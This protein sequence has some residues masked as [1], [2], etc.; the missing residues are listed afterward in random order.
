MRWRNVSPRLLGYTEAQR[1]TFE[2]NRYLKNRLLTKQIFIPTEHGSWVFLLSPLAIGLA[3][4]GKFGWPQV[5]WLVAALAAFM[6]RQ[7]LTV[8]VKILSGRRPRKDLLPA[9]FWLGMY[10]LIAFSAGAALAW[11]GFGFVLWLV[12]PAMLVMGWHLWLVSRKAER[13]K[14]G[15]E[16]IGSAVLALVA[17]A[18]YWIGRGGMDGYGWLLWL[19]LV[20]QNAAS[21][22]YAYLRLE[23]R[24]LPS[25]PDG[26]TRLSMGRRSLIYTTF[27]LVC[28]AG[29]SA[30]AVIPPWVWTA[31]LVQWCESL[32]GTWRPAIKERP[33]R[34]GIRQMIV[35][36]IFT[37][38]FVL[39]WFLK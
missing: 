19:L 24:V 13:R 26:K 32:Y 21:I 10:G 15:V 39:T 29:L 17:P 3:L 33:M 6:A 11:L 5:V 31:Y 14:P 35:S 8:L 4:G 30:A 22:V 23:Q 9:L 12:L 36:I 16:I 37:L 20:L 2:V 27:N 38:V 28:T 34:I 7:P 1:S 18:S 25:E